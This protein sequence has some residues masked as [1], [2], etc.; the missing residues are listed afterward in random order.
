[1]TS[2]SMSNGPLD[3]VHNKIKGLALTGGAF[4]V[5]VADIRPLNE[6]TV[7]DPTTF[8]FPSAVSFAV[9]IPAAAV[10]SARES[11]SEEMREAYKYCNKKLKAIGMQMVEALGSAGHKARFVDPSERVDPERLL[12]PI[13]HKA[14]AR[15]SGLGWIGKNG[16]LMS[17]EY[18][19]RFRMGTVLTDMPVP[20]NP[21]MLDDD[22][23]DCT[24]CID[25]CP[26]NSLKGSV[27]L[28]GRSW[29]RDEVIDWEKCG[30]YEKALIGDGSRPEKACGKCIAVCPRSR[31]DQ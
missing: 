14:I 27:D 24:M 25:M 17:E 5:G 18:G 4:K 21:S 8:D 15:L 11:P 20:M 7:G 1:M 10:M 22:C 29:D 19:P 12:G 28:K 23:G 2:S 6:L 3:D 16:L 30:R 9:E 31:L 26:T 13:S